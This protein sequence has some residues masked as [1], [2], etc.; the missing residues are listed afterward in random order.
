MRR[1]LALLLALLLLTSTVLAYEVPTEFTDL[2]T[3]MEEFMAAYGL[4]ENNFS[5]SYYNTVTGESYVF[6][7]GR[8]MVA[9]S[10]FKLPLNMYYYEMERD[11]EI[12]SDAYIPRADTTLADAHYNS[13]VW[14]DNEDA[15]GMLYN[16]GDFRT[17]KTKMRKYFSMT[18]EEIDPVYYQRNYYCTRMM[19]E[20]LQYLYD[21]SGDFSEM[22]GYMKE[23]QPGEYFK[24]GVTA[25]E[26]AHKYGWF[27]G[28]V[29]DVGIIYAPNPSSWRSIPRTS[30]ARR[31]APRRPSS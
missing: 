3:A 29:N 31:S 8:F 26:V 14:S 7:D 16:L 22:L 9:A 18:D 2:D 6:N 21:N 19:M 13:L 1:F 4:N 20:A 28:A 11:G 25:Y 23:A 27:E 12:A 30:T 17:Y 10:T 24:A 5:I 15:L